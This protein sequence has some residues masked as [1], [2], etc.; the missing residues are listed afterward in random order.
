MPNFGWQQD[1]SI[2][3]WLFAEP[4]EFDFFQATL[5]LERLQPS[6]VPAGEGVDPAVEALRFRS[7]ITHVFAASEVQA[8]APGAP[9]GAPPTLT[10]NLLSLGGVSGPLPNAYSDMLIESA[11]RK[12]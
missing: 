8:L 11:W 12:D 10:A 9:S 2:A 4:W 7:D 5:L 6:R 1:K 3:A